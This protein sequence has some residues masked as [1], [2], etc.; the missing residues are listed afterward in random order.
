[1]VIILILYGSGAIS[2]T[3]HVCNLKRRKGNRLFPAKIGILDDIHW[4]PNEWQNAWSDITP[5]DWKE[6]IEIQAEEIRLRV[7]VKLVSVRKNLDS[8]AAIVNPFGG[9]YPETDIKNTESLNKIF[10][11]VTSGGLFVNVADIPGYWQYNHVLKRLVDATPPIYFGLSPHDVGEIRKFGLTPFMKMMG[12]KG[13]NTEGTD[14]F[15]WDVE[16][17]KEFKKAGRSLGKIKVERALTIENNVKTVV[18]PMERPE[19]ALTPLCLVDYGNGTFVISLPSMNNKWH[20][21]NKA[22][23]KVIVGLLI[24]LLQT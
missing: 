15:D 17:T 22:L 16:I 4:N 14:V 10:D 21:E 12:L 13:Y 5:S 18:K 23:K 8:Y 7:K 20:R 9:A 11:Y 3:W 2:K 6:E 24:E 1:V 19:G